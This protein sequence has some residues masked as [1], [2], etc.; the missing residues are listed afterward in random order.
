MDNSNKQSLIFSPITK[1][2]REK[3]IGIFMDDDVRVYDNDDDQLDYFITK[4]EN[5]TDDCFYDYTI[6]FAEIMKELGCVCVGFQFNNDYHKK[7]DVNTYYGIWFSKVTNIQ[8]LES[9]K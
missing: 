1:E 9:Q 2:D 7:G 3:I 5:E 8:P 4:L 6:P